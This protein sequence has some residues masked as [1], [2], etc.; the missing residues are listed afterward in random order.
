[1]SVRQRLAALSS[2]L[3]VLVL[4]DMAVAGASKAEAATASPTVSSCPQAPPSD[5]ENDQNCPCSP[6]ESQQKSAEPAE[7]KTPRDTQQTFYHRMLMFLKL[8]GR[9]P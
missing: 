2:G 8:L 1:M 6:T 4:C 3:I 9:E 5:C 7:K